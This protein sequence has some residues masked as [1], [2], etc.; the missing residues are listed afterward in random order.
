MLQGTQKEFCYPTS[1]GAPRYE[2][3]FRQVRSLSIDL[4]IGQFLVGG[5]V[6]RVSSIHLFVNRQSSGA[7]HSVQESVEMLALFPNAHM[8]VRKASGCQELDDLAIRADQQ[9]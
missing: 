9:T 5:F 4:D 1:I 3:A 6:C 2:H 8:L 7:R